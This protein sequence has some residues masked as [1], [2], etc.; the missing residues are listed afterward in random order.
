M[1]ALD[2]LPRNTIILIVSN[3]GGALLLFVLNALI[4]RAAGETGLGI[5]AVSLAWAYPL[6]LLVEFGLGTLITRDAAANPQRT[7]SLLAMAAVARLM[8]GVAA[9]IGLFAAAPLLSRDPAIITAIRISAPMAALTPFFS[10]FTAV[11]RAR[12]GMLPVAY[13]NLG[14]LAAQVLLTAG[15]FMGGSSINAALV[16]NVATSGWQLVAA[17]GWWRL[18][19]RSL[20]PGVEYRQFGH[21]ERRALVEMLRRALPFAS[22]ALLKFA[23]YPFVCISAMWCVLVVA[24]VRATR[25]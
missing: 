25:A 14:M 4:G 9:M 7:D 11:F 18:S 22:A 17:W 5:Y 15:A 8:F 23:P 19:F 6:G 2:R 24:A 1:T 3:V 10:A 16:I 12:G 20:P 13:L 21:A